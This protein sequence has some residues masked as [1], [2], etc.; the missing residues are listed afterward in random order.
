MD[1]LR[2]DGFNVGLDHYASAQDISLA[3][4]ARGDIDQDPDTLRRWLKPLLCSSAK[5]FQL[6]DTHF[7]SRVEQILRLDAVGERIG[8]T[9]SLGK[10]LISNSSAL[11]REALIAGLLIFVVLI[12]GIF[13]A[14]D[15]EPADQTNALPVSSNTENSLPASQQFETVSASNSVSFERIRNEP[16]LDASRTQT[17][18]VNADGSVLARISRSNIYLYNLRSSNLSFLKDSIIAEPESAFQRVL[19]SRDENRFIT[20]T[21][22]QLQY[23]D[24]DTN[25]LLSQQAIHQSAS[26]LTLNPEEN[27]L[28]V[29]HSDGTLTRWSIVD[30]TPFLT[31]FVSEPEGHPF[32]QESHRMIRLHGSSI[33]DL[34]F[35]PETNH[36]LSTDSYR[37]NKVSS[38]DTSPS[39]VE[40]QAQRNEAISAI[41]SHDRTRFITG[42]NDDTARMTW[43]SDG[44]GMRVSTSDWVTSVAFSPNDSLIALGSLGNTV[45]VVNAFTGKDSLVIEHANS[46]PLIAFSRDG[47]YIATGSYDDTVRLTRLADGQRIGEIVHGDIIQDMAFSA[48]GD[49]LA[50][51]ARDNTIQLMRV[52][53]GAVLWSTAIE[54]TPNTMAFHPDGS[55]LVVGSIANRLS[56]IDNR[57]GTVEANYD[58]D[59]DVTS[60]AFSPD[61]RHLLV[62]VAG[63]F[64]AVDV[65]HLRTRDDS[66]WTFSEANSEVQQVLYSADNQHVLITFEDTAGGA[67]A[68]LLNAIDGKV[69]RRFNL[70]SNDAAAVFS[71]DGKYIL[72]ANRP[73]G[74]VSAMRIEDIAELM[75]TQDRSYD[76]IID[77]SNDG[78]SIL[79]TGGDSVWLDQ[80]GE[81]HS[82]AAAADV[83]M[84]IVSRLGGHLVLAGGNKL[85]AWN[86]ATEVPSR[87]ELNPDSVS[88]AIVELGIDREALWVKD[89]S[90][91]VY[92]YDVAQSRI[93]ALLRWASGPGWWILPLLG[94]LTLTFWWFTTFWLRKAQAYLLRRQSPEQPDV[95]G[96]ALQDLGDTLFEAMPLFRLAQQLR[97]RRRAPSDRLHAGKTVTETV[98]GGTFRPVYH[99]R[100]FIPEY[101]VLVDRSTFRDHQA[102]MA[103]DLISNLRADGVYITLFFFDADPRIC[104]PEDELMPP[105]TLDTLAHIYSEYRLLIF[106]DA[107]VF[108]SPITGGISGW[109]N[110]MKTWSHR[111]LLTPES[112]ALWGHREA[113]LMDLFEIQHATTKGLI[114]LAWETQEET[115]ATLLNEGRIFPPSIRKRPMRWVSNAAP[116]LPDIRLMLAETHRYLGVD[117]FY[118]LA[119]GAVY[120]G[121]HWKLTLHLGRLLEGVDG[122]MLLRADRLSLL[123][124]LPWFRH[125]YM[126][127]WLREHFIE[128]L[129]EWE[130]V[131]IRD[132]FNVMMIR[133]VKG[134]MSEAD[135][136]IALEEPQSLRAIAKRVIQRD[137]NKQPRGS[138]WEDYVFLDFMLVQNRLL[139]MPAPHALRVLLNKTSEHRIRKKAFRTLAI[140]L[141]TVIIGLIVLVG[142]LELWQQV[143]PTPLPVELRSLIPA[144]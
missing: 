37:L 69:V 33:S 38:G 124:R 126:P 129:E 138:A 35:I 117:T 121:V 115:E 94:T 15:T 133:P 75:V 135:I 31:A 114:H 93:S 118:W 57:D 9:G 2:K 32:V 100:Q 8:E 62:G 58:F 99:E 5:E 98:R 19:F 107:G 143:S 109:T 113:I 18:S 87:L 122:E 36:L 53:D 65:Y 27:V 82:V 4:I 77:L 127:D 96:F 111:Y 81:L 89:L 66:T 105:S 110:K 61:G 144:N 97:R 28:A 86:T 10:D 101:L 102:H 137:R 39:M 134:D 45:R 60:V 103:E 13:N 85:R 142:T 104:F 50:S 7:D 141:G 55:I 83:D 20:T 125:G 16:T 22:L 24:L 88:N 136:K 73:E 54:A 108:F 112:P 56:Y 6:F 78:Q 67:V 132:A 51:A 14:D 52:S 116:P 42:G 131:A 74:W 120:P 72:T 17:I 41:F 48:Q 12:L 92:V 139:A 70:T 63:A 46:A 29:G 23:W 76:Q 40:L 68:V 26:W 90:G 30:D 25:T 71:Q 130:E 43:M 1:D 95:T 64:D 59:T 44:D 119:A 91:A 3:L 47:L 106:S 34:A 140:L 11:R 123:A 49:F 21:N 80:K 128:H 79:S 84:G